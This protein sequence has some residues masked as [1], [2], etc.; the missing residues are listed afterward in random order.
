MKKRILTSLI[1]SATLAFGLL[2]GCGSKA[3]ETT[4]EAPAAEA[5]AEAPADATQE[6]TT[7]APAADGD[8]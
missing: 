8:K 2:T 3:P 7:E 1:L 4:T 5:T 6:T